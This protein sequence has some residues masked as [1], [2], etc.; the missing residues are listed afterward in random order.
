M[1]VLLENVKKI[2]DEIILITIR[3]SSGLSITLDSKLY[4]DGDMKDF[5]GKEVDVLL[6]G[7][8]SPIMEHRLK[9]L[10]GNRKENE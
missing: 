8:R 7:F 4:K 6:S 1:K 3:L 2:Q 5:I 10:R 9:L